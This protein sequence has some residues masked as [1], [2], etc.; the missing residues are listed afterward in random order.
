MYYVCPVCKTENK[1]DITFPIEEYACKSCSNLIDVN[2]NSPSKVL[3]KPIENVVLEV[4]QKGTLN[5]I[6]YTVVAIIVRKYGSNTYWREYYLKDQKG[7]DAFLSESDGHW[8]FLHS[9]NKEDIKRKSWNS[10]LL[11]FNSINY[12]RYET[13]ECHIH[14]AAGFFEEKLN[15]GIS[16]YKEYVNGTQMISEEKSTD[17]IQYFFGHHISKYTIKKAFNITNLPNYSGIGIVQPF[18]LNVQQAINIIGIAAIF[19]CLLQLYVFSSRTN[20]TIFEQEVYFTEVKDRELVSKSFELSGGSAPLEVQVYSNVDNSWANVGIGLVNENTNEVVY[21]SKDIER[22]SGFEDGESWSEGSQTEEFNFCGVA[23]GKYHF[24]ISAEKQ[25]PL[26][27]SLPA[28]YVSDDN[29]ILL[30]RDSYGTINVTNNKTMETVAFGDAK[31]LKK[32]STAI[33]QLVRQT[34]GNKDVDSLL[35]ASLLSGVTS[36]NP[37]NSSVKI[38]A[39]WF[40]V[41]FWNFGIILL[42]MVIFVVVCYFGRRQFNIVKWNNS[43]NSPYS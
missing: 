18:Y 12:R 23:P 31:I 9:I 10:I 26:E 41:S 11:E 2:K 21:T 28:S 43:S 25:Q 7:K 4:G 32:D 15:M 42:L 5:T 27:V 37:E 16:T 30:S 35:T 24:I 17:G 34:L 39:T 33:G 14:A 13:T 6:E 20:K 3:K 40:P 1:H 22:Y 19:I 8:V 29:A 36:T 38:K